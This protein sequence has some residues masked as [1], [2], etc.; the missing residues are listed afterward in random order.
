MKVKQVFDS[1]LQ[2][3]RLEARTQRH[4]KSVMKPVLE[5]IGEQHVET[6]RFSDYERIKSALRGRKPSSLNQSLTVT[7]MVVQYAVNLGAVPQSP[8]AGARGVK[9]GNS[10]RDFLS[11]SERDELLAACTDSTHKLMI[12]IAVFTGLRKSEM[13]GLRWDDVDMVARTITV[14]RTM[15]RPGTTKDY[16]KTDSSLRVIPFPEKL[17]N[18]LF[19]KR[20]EGFIF[21]PSNSE[22]ANPGEEIL[23]KYT[24]RQV[25]WHS[26]RN[27]FASALVQKN[28]SLVKIAHLL[29][30]SKVS[31]TLYRYAR[32]HGTSQLHEEVN[33]L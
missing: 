8:F 31:N 32:V 12:A 2:S 30:H 21:S 15:D 26:L 29:G 6:L 7:R 18:L 17:H 10:H 9:S 5:E 19:S 1:Y 23:R 3:T 13:F 14:R 25:C 24:D 4:Y 27:T 28:V 22:F 33:L 11:I 16:G 20:S